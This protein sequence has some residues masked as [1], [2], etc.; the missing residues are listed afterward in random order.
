MHILDL[1]KERGF[2]AQVTYEEDLYK[3]L[4]K[5]PTK[6]YIGFDPTAASLHFGHFI[7]ILAMMHMQRAGHIPI[8]LV[9][10]GTVMIGDPSGKSDMRKML[11]LDDINRN[12]EKIHQQLSHFLNFSDGKAIMANNADWLL[13]LNYVEFIR[14]IGVHF[15]VNRMLTAECYKQRLERGLTFLE[16]NYMLMQGYDFLE[17]F[18]RHGCRLQMGGDDQWSN[19]LAGADLIRRKE[20]EDAFACTFKLLMTHEGKKM[21]KTERGALWLD[22]ELCSPYEFYQYWRNVS[23]QDVSK[24]LSMLTFLPMEEVRRLSALEG[25]DINEAKK[26]LAFECTK[27]VHG[28]DEAQKAQEASAALFSGGSAMD[29]V[30]TYAISRDELEADS[31]LT[32]LLNTS[33]L[34]TSKSEARKMVMQ[35]AVAI[36]DEKVT[37]IDTLISYEQIG[38]DGLLLR[39]GKKNYVRLIMKI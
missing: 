15:S 37:D 18:K 4:E 16:F 10:G 1:L 13:A 11:T 23:D 26:V 28:E 25:A 19:M 20:R 34:C 14:D 21:G 27:I 35:G 39:R 33:G 7:P 6:F 36:G 32:T 3:Q 30:P 5:E 8:A 31:R 22:P 12:A 2:I 24:S 9:G 29:E 17:L 38:S